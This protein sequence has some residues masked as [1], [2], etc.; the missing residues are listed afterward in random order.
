MYTEYITHQM[1]INIYHYDY[2]NHCI[3]NKLP[4]ISKTL[5]NAT[6]QYTLIHFKN[7]IHIL[8]ISLN[9]NRSSLLFFE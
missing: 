7:H 9:Y 3:S 5:F 8:L 6:I 4:F 2:N 1:A